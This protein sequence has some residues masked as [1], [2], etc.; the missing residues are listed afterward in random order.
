MKAPPHQP[1]RADGIDAR[2]RLLA[3]ALDLFSEHGYEK[4]SVRAIAREARVNLGAVAYYFGDK[5]G[6][7]QALFVEAPGTEPPNA[8]LAFAEPDRPLPEAMRMFYADFLEPLKQGDAVRKVMKLH[9]REMAE[10][11][12]AFQSALESDIRPQHD[13]L[14]ALLARELGLR[15]PDLDAQRLAAAIAGL[16]VHFFAFSEGVKTLA[17]ALLASPRS[18]DALAARLAGYAISMIEGERAR[19][20]AVRSAERRPSE[21]SS[22]P[23]RRPSEPPSDPG[24]RP[25]EPPSATE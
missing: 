15:R 3:A 16:G 13:A 20:A 18:I 14:V 9:F 24:R 8:P 7:Y 19:R 23:E 22:D 5:E 25:S 1:V 17:P 2:Q 4:T 6:L 12:G 10:P 11:T 21:P